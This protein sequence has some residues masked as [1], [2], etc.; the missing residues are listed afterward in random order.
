MG[1]MFIGRLNQRKAFVGTFVFTMPLSHYKTGRRPFVAFS[2]V[3]T[4]AVVMHRPQIIQST[5]TAYM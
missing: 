4:K 5:F 1:R 3:T 2:E